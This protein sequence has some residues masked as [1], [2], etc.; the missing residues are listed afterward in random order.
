MPNEID[1][2]KL[3]EQKEKIKELE[4]A[5]KSNFKEGNFSEL[6]KTAKELEVLDSENKLSKKLLAKVADVKAK[7]EA[8][9]KKG[10]ITEYEKML[11]KLYKEDQ[12]EKLTA[13]AKEFKEFDPENKTP[14]KWLSKVQKIQEKAKAKEEKEALKVQ[15]EAEK[16]KEKAMKEEM[17]KQKEVQK[18]EEAPKK[19][20]PAPTTV[21]PT[22]VVSPV[23][24]TVKAE[25]KPEIKQEPKKEVP[26]GNIFTSMFK[27][28]EEDKQ[29]EKSIIDTIVAKTDEKKTVEKHTPV[30]KIKPRK[31]EK[32]IEG[33][34][35][36]TFSKVFMNFTAIFIVFSAA[37]LYVEFL[38]EENTMLGLVG[39]EET[40]GSRLKSA[41]DENRQH[42]IDEQKLEKDID[43][44]K[45]GYED[46]VMKKVNAV[47]E[48]RINWPD[49]FAKINEV[50][51]SVYELNDFF[52]YIE[53][54]N[55]SFDAKN[56]TIRVTGTLSD[57]LGRNLT[58][59][60]EL[61][62]AFEYYPKDKNNPNDPA[63][64][65]F[66]GFREMTSYSKTLDQVTGRYISNF[67]LSFSLNE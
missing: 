15:K 49:I 3:K 5:M 9:K 8:E 45:E 38:D 13:L 6:E 63:Q 58:K 30:P 12:F 2:N 60:V 56:K 34:A 32:K 59:L 52:K 28:G 22:P 23:A 66:S 57:P 67:Q 17:K 48:E 62:E 43:T 46:A 24:P 40:T 18:Q 20:I 10:K 36:L 16:A 37:F 25:V 35:L 4:K 65:Y 31:I 41:A 50:T 19:T 44:Y 27:K 21:A 47:I 55:Y 42:K 39:I 61:E 11:K 64:P 33:T 14:D 7:A 54:N 29:T 26:K 51:K 53:Y 1:K